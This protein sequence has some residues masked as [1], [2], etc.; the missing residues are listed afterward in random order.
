LTAIIMPALGV[1]LEEALVLRWL[2]APGDDCEEG[3]VVAEVET[4]KAVVEIESPARGRLA[5]IL[6]PE[7]DYVAVGKPIGILTAEGES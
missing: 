5:E 3:E 1:A 4:D 7:G 2:K 6:V